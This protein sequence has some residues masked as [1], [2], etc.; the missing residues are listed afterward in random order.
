MVAIVG[1]LP[2]QQRREAR[3]TYLAGSNPRKQAG[4]FSNSLFTVWTT[5]SAFGLI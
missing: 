4:K 2:E 1:R 5:L 3:K